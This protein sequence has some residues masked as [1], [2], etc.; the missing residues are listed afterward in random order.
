MRLAQLAQFARIG[1]DVDHPRAG[2]ETVG[3]PGGAVVEARTDTDQQ[4]AFVQYP[5]GEAR[6]VHAEH[7]QRQRMLRRQRAQRHQRGGG[8]QGGALGQ[9]LRRVLRARLRH[10]A[11]Q[12]QHRPRRCIDHPRRLGDL[13][14][15]G[16][17][18]R[19]A[20]RRVG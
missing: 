3:A 10:A 9:R 1:V 4:I 11:A 6:A 2:A 17:R 20:P 15:I 18:R 7:A 19:F 5:V 14:R 16:R 13:Q 8:G 12:V